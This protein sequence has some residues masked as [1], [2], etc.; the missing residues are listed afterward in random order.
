MLLMLGVAFLIAADVVFAIAGTAWQ[1]FVGSCPPGGCSPKQ[2][3]KLGVGHPRSYSRKMSSL[4]HA[5][6]TA[7]L[8]AFEMGWEIL[9]ALILGFALSGVVQAV[10]TKGEMSRLLRDYQEFRARWAVEPVRP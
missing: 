9:W 4:A 7:L 5:L 6:F 3:P 10:V 2:A 1:V 8:M